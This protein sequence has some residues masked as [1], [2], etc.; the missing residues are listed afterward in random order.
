MRKNYIEKKEQVKSLPELKKTNLN[1]QQS[2]IDFLINFSSAYY[3]ENL[4]NKQKLE[5]FLN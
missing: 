4:T 1:P 5:F 2:T 3:V